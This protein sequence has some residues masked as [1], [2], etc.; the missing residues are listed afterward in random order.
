MKPLSVSPTAISTKKITIYHS[1]A[2]SCYDAVS[3]WSSQSGDYSVCGISATAPG[4]P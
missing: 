1:N 4:C 3:S 2:D